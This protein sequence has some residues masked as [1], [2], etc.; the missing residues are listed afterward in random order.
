MFVRGAVRSLTNRKA[1]D[2]FERNIAEDFPEYLAFMTGKDE[3]RKARIVNAPGEQ[4]I[5]QFEEVK[6]GKFGEVL[7]LYI[8]LKFEELN[9]SWLKRKFTTRWINR[10]Y[11]IKQLRRAL[12]STIIK[13]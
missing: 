1:M 11:I 10:D 2:K 7:D 8:K 12:N 13:W 4:F 3:L 5:D 9:E 6:E